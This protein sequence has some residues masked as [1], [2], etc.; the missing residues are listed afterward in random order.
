[1][2][3]RLSLS[4]SLSLAAA[5]GAPAP[6]D[7]EPVAAL[8]S[9]L[10][11]DGAADRTLSWSGFDC[12]GGGAASTSPSSSFDRPACADSF[13]VEITGT[14]GRTFNPVAAWGEAMPTTQAAC[15]TAF[16]EV[17]ISGRATGGAWQSVLS[18][19]TLQGQWFATRGYCLMPALPQITGSPHDRIR[20]AVKAYSFPLFAVIFKRA[21]GGV[22]T[23]C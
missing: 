23:L 18:R 20:I 22:S 5:C 10:C 17:E 1:M 8:H 7:D 19:R 16:A 6:G 12:F 14:R 11:T 3:N 2:H 9:E 21:Y 13:T 4:L 15:R